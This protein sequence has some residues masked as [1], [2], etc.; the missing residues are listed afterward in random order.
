MKVLYITQH[1]NIPTGFA[2]I[3]MYKMAKA[4]VGHGHEVTIVCGSHDGAKT[5]LDGEFI[6]GKRNGFYEGIE[7]IEFDIKYSN[8][9]SFVKRTGVF[10]LYVWKTVGLALFYKYDILFAST[11]PLT[12]GIP[13]IFARWLRGK[14]F[15]FE[16]RDLWPELPKAMGVIKNP[17]ILW[18]MGLLEFICYRSATKLVGLSDGIVKGIA[19]RGVKLNKIAN[20]PNGCDLDIFSSN[21]GDLKIDGVQEND[22]LCLYSGTH[23]IANG[24]DILI[25]V[26]AE[27]TNR[28]NNTVKFILVG[29]GKLKPGLIIK[30]NE[31][32]LKNII[33]LDPLNKADLSK[34]MN[35][36]DIGMQLLAN[37][38]AFY[39]GT[40]PNKFFDYIC[41]GLP[42][43]N[44]YPGWIS[45]LITQYNCG[46]TVSPDNPEAFA[47]SLIKLEKE[48]Y[49]LPEM[50]VNARNLAEN[51]F[52]RN[53]LSD[54][55]VYWL[56]S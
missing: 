54:K 41:V 28:G 48:K 38:P 31:Q 16:V 14:K 20:I 53:L 27:L 43:L 24:L 42:V 22:F 44:N 8:K 55:W 26:A 5:G 51:E 45:E 23:G 9:F 36:C 4:L 25:D 47:D 29:D 15:V 21:D 34:L 30:A 3:R 17:V 6:K 50:S 40:S 39:Y 46:I 56:T 13:G 10:L 7:I 18:L 12:V 32:R 49:K 19:R 33:F 1:F 37:I 2:G 52:D 35:T 11:T